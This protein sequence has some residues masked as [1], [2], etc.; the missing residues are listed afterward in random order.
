MGNQMSKAIFLEPDPE[1]HRIIRHIHNCAHSQLETYFQGNAAPFLNWQHQMEF[2]SVYLT[3][4]ISFF[5]QNTSKIKSQNVNSGWIISGLNSSKLVVLNVTGAVQLWN[6]KKGW[7]HQKML[8][9]HYSSYKGPDFLFFNKGPLSLENVT[10]SCT[11]H[12]LIAC[13]YYFH[14][15]KTVKRTQFNV[16][17]RKN[18]FE[19]VI[20]VDGLPGNSQKWL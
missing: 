9:I 17:S 18:K 8:N 1:G 5:I 10:L 14:N 7:V 4:S 12:I 3:F 6:H 11:C 20:E 15:K 2:A 16:S 19:G 13:V